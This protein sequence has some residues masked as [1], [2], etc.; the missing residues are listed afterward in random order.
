MLQLTESKTG[1][2]SKWLTIVILLMLLVVSAGCGSST[3]AS[4]QNSGG[5]GGNGGGGGTPPGNPPQ[6]KSPVQFRFGDAPADLVAA[7]AVTVNSVKVTSQS[8]TITNILPNPITIELAHLSDTS[9]PLATL[10]LPQGNYTQLQVA[11]SN[12]SVTYFDP[13]TY[14]PVQKQVAQLSPVTVNFSP[15]LKVGNDAGVLSLDFDLARTVNLDIVNDTFSLNTPV[16]NVSQAQV[17]SAGQ[18][19]PETGQVDH[20]VGQVTAVS[21]S[22]FTMT[23]GE[24][25]VPLTLA[26][27]N[28]TA[29]VNVTLGTLAGML[30]QVD[31]TTNPDG[32]FLAQHVQGFENGTG[33]TVQGLLGGYT[34]SGNFLTVV[35]D[36]VGT[37]MT[38]AL[39]GT[40]ISMNNNNASYS[41]NTQG[42][43]MTGLSLTFDLYHITPGQNVQILSS[44]SMQ[45]D[46]EGN[47]GLLTPDSLIL[48]QQ[49]L[50]GT[51]A[52]YT[53]G[54]SPNAASFDLLLPTDNTSY[55]TAANPSAVT[56]HIYQQAGTNL[57]N[58]SA[59]IQNGQTVRVRG[60]LFFNAFGIGGKSGGNRPNI[61][62]GAAPNTS[63]PTSFQMVASRISQ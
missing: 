23:L 3:P 60:L 10:A 30:V 59:G 55:L 22:S 58:L 52:N 13:I 8:A 32:T 15:A 41:V 19:L 11:L 26:T 51:V 38:P 34:P 61:A 35:Q 29:F 36:G 21:G 56:V 40:N 4:S 49:T 39:V 28:S 1:K 50:S 14:L 47:A 62:L 46:P 17:P 7:F 20:L 44:S 57:L 43:D 53:A 54:S 6:A 5:S 27:N 24:S 48:E 25:G 42:V 12:A 9:A 2:V 16:I 45:S 18:E 31:G 33:V 37:S 63:I